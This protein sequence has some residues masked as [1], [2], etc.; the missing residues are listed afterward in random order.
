MRYFLV[1]E[2][3]ADRDAFDKAMQEAARVIKDDGIR[4]VIIDSL[5]YAKMVSIGIC[6]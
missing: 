4:N 3:N 1:N 5:Q 6:K 2:Y